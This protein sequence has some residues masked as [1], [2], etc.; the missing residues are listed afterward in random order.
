MTTLNNQQPHTDH[1]AIVSVSLTENQD[2]L[3]V[4]G[5]IS[6][7]NV[8]K[9]RNTGKRLLAQ[10]TPVQIT[11]DLQAVESSDNSGLVLL[12]AWIRDAR[13]VN[14]SLVFQNVPVFLQ[15]MS[16]VFGLETIIHG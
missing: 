14:K 2:R 15:R 5:S 4:V 6:F 9:L 7:K 10:K 13:H 12:L 8:V 11:V 3:A 16:Q 1:D